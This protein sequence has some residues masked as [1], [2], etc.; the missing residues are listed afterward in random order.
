MMKRLFVFMGAA[1]MAFTG[2]RCTQPAKTDAGTT[3]GSAAST[4]G[5]QENHH[6]TQSMKWKTYAKP[7]LLRYGK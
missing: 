1:L 3:A 6:L 4:E 5:Y 2:M 7:K